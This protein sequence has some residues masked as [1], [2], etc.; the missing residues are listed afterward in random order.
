MN[1][2]TEFWIEE[3]KKI[4]ETGGGPFTRLMIAKRLEALHGISHQEAMNNVSTAFEFDKDNKPRLFKIS[5]PG[6]WELT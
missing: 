6:W 2:E 3:V 1:A 4:M 5:K